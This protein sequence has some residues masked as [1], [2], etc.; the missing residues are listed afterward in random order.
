MQSR[1]R[2]SYR[3]GV[4]NRLASSLAE[5]VARLPSKRRQR[6]QWA[7]YGAANTLNRDA[8]SVVRGEGHTRVGVSAN[9]RVLPRSRR[10]P[11]VFWQR[12]SCCRSVSS[13][14]PLHSSLSAGRPRAR[15]DGVA[16]CISC[17]RSAAG[18]PRDGSILPMPP[19]R[20]ARCLGDSPASAPVVSARTPYP[21]DLRDDSARRAPGRQQCRV[22]P[23]F[24]GR[25]G[26]QPA[27][28]TR[29]SLMRKA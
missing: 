13:T 21:G 14:R 2:E 29:C 23:S 8:D 19:D 5:A 22:R 7:G 4:A 20:R 11:A 18:W 28:T 25:Q 24:P 1:M 6:Y 26:G 10:L 15:C 12:G 27:G 3:K 16:S 9:R 17:S